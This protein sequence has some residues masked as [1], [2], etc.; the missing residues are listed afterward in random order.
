M[1]FNMHDEGWGGCVSANFEVGEEQM[2][3]SGKEGGQRED[4]AKD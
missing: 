3:E 2:K 1:G 4:C